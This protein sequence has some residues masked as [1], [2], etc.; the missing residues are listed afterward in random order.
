MEDE[1]LDEDSNGRLARQSLNS[2]VLAYFHMM[3]EPSHDWTDVKPVLERFV[4]LSM[5]SNDP[6]QVRVS[7]RLKERTG[8]SLV[9][10]HQGVVAVAA[11]GA[12]S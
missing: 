1:V 12:Q 2:N 4:F 9:V 3:T 8:K 11:A 10:I 6:L 5:S 7:T